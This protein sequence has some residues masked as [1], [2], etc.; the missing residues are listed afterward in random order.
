[1]Y[2]HSLQFLALLVA[3]YGL[4]WL[5]YR[6]KAARLGVLLVASLFFYV[7]WSPWPLLIF[8]AIAASDHLCIRGMVRWRDRPRVRKLLMLTSVVVNLGVLGTFKYADMLRRTAVW[9]LEPLGIAVRTE[10]FN[11]LLPIGLSFVCFQ[12]LSYVVDV[13][14]GE[15]S[16]EHSFGEHL[17]YLLFFPQVVAGPI[18]RAADLLERFNQVPQVSAE[19]GARGLYR[20]AI[21]LVKK[22]AIADVLGTGLVDPVFSAPHEFT[23]AECLVAAV[24]Y[25]FE[26]YCDFSAYSDI[27]IGAA[28]LFG[29]ELPEN[30]NSPYLAR[31]LFEFWNRWHI[32]L[33][34]WLRDYL[35]IPLGGNRA[36]RPRVLFNVMVVMVLGGLWHGAD[37]RFA[38]WGGVH[39]L[40][41]VLTRLWWWWRGR[42]EDPGWLRV[43]LGMLGTFAVV[44]LT[45]IVFR[46]PNLE[47]AGQMYLRLLEGSLGLANV[48]PLVWL[49]L[50]VAAVSHA[51][52][53][54]LYVGAAELFV[55]LPAPVRA[56][57][58]VGLGLGLRHL[59][60]VEA[61]PYVY[62]QF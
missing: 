23:S 17:L 43:G 7:A 25:T 41:L 22:L 26:L 28:A 51:V 47:L 50:A 1:M 31:N 40:M 29:F 61:R 52:P 15:A 24:A 12:A 30:F 44:V 49:M 39:G 8:L 19:A 21:G 10:P 46:A 48:T 60:A 55:R 42:A 58:L 2:F 16:G 59:S 62:F 37:W 38:L 4:Y 3:T 11:L 6:H 35:Y 32:S 36:S 57:V 34:T 45:R 56:V 13:Y 53:E 54:R 33:S 5:V 18:I 14:R 20:V 9:A 27:A